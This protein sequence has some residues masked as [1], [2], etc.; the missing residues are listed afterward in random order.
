MAV[1]I[2]IGRSVRRLCSFVLLP[3]DD[4][5]AL[6]C[7]VLS[8]ASRLRFHDRIDAGQTR[9]QNGH[10]HQPVTISR[11]VRKRD[12]INMGVM[13]PKPAVESAVKLK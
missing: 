9:D 8:H 7:P 1:P 11:I 10:V 2:W 12:W 4:A 5:C 13:S 3:A 6:C